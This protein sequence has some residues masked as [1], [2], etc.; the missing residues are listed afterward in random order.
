MTA[1]IV[2]RLAAAAVIVEIDVSETPQIL[3]AVLRSSENG[4]FGIAVARLPVA[5]TERAGDFSQPRKFR[6]S[7][8]VD[9]GSF[10][11]ISRV[12]Q[13]ASWGL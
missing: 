4:F 10:L 6:N 5:E 9:V 1:R 12:E 7:F 3:P 2:V 8:A 13:G 11:D